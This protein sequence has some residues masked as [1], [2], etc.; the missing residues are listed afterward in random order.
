MGGNPFY[1]LD[2]MR[3]TNCKELFSSYIKNKI[4]IG[5]S[6]GSMVFGDTI[7]LV[8]ELHPHLNNDVGLIDYTG[9]CLTHINVYSHVSGYIETVDRF[10]ERMH[11]FENR[12]GLQFTCI[13]YGQAVFI[14]DQ[15]VVVL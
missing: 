8:Y 3:K 4:M 12:K 9:L 2:I 1:L 7:G 10:L 14:S 15:E 11:D 5:A 6:A 13:N